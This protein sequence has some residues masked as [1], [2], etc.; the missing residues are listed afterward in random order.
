MEIKQKLEK[1]EN[2]PSLYEFFSF[3]GYPVLRSLER[4][5]EFSELPTGAQQLIHSAHL[6]SDIDI[7]QIFRIYHIELNQ[8][9]IRRTDIRRI[10]EPF[11][12]KYSHIYALFVFSTPKTPYSELAFVSPDFIPLRTREGKDG[13]RLR[14][15]TLSLNPKSPYRT[16]LEILNGIRP[17]GVLDPNEIWEKH[18]QAFSVQ[19]VTKQFYEGYKQVFNEL[20]TLLKSQQGDSTWAH[21]F[22]HQL[23]NRIMF[24]YFIQRKGWL[25]GENGEPAKDFI[26]QFW[27]AYKQSNQP[28]NTF[29][30][31]WLF[32]LF[33][34]AFNKH[35]QA[36]YEYPKWLPSWI[37]KSFSEAPYLNGGLYSENELDRQL[38]ATIPDEFFVHL[39]DRTKDNDGKDDENTPGFFERYNFT[40]V[41]SGRFDEEVAVD[42]EVI[43][44]VYESLVNIEERGE[45][46]KEID[47]RGMAGIFYTPR[48]EIDLMCRLSLVDYLTNHLGEGYRQLLNE[49]VFSYEESDKNDIDGKVGKA[50]LWNRLDRLLREV[51][52]CDPAC[53]SGSFLVGM[54][55]VLDDLQERANRYLGREE[56]PYERRKRIIRDQLYGVDVMEWAVHIAELRLWLQL[57]VE[58]ELPEKALLSSPLLPNLSFKLRSGDSLIQEVAGINLSHYREY[59]DIPSKLRDRLREL[60]EKKRGYYEGEQWLNEGELKAEERE[61]FLGILAHKKNELFKRRSELKLKISAPPQ[62]ALPGYGEPRYPKERESWQRELREVE[63]ELKEVDKVIQELKR[64]GKTPFLWNIAF[65]EIFS[66][67]KGGFDIVIGNPPYVRREKIA[68]PLMREEDFPPRVW[69]RLKKEYREKLQESVAMIWRDFFRNNR[70]LQGKNDLYVY[71]YFHALSLLNKKGSFC[72]ITSNSWLDVWFGKDLQEFLLRYGHPKMIIDN[73]ARRSFE[74]ADINTVIV[75]LAPPSKEEVDDE[76]KERRFVRFVTFKVPFEEIL[77]PVIFEEIWD[78][79]EYERRVDVDILERREYRAI[80]RDAYSLLVEGMEESKIGKGVYRGNK[81][82]G[83]YLRAPVI[84]FKIMEKGAGKL[85]KLGEIAKVETYLN[86]EADGFFLVRKVGGDEYICVIQNT[87]EEGQGR[88]F[89]IEARFVKPLIKSPNELRRIIVSASQTQWLLIVFPEK[90][91]LLTERAK[92]YIRWGERMGFSQRPGCRKRRPWWKLPRQAHRPG[93]IMWSRLHHDRHLVF[94]NPEEVAYTNFYA[95]WPT[96]MDEKVFTALLNATYLVLFRELVGRTPCGGGVLKTDGVDIHRIPVI[97]PSLVPPSQRARLICAFERLAQREVGSIFEELGFVICRERRCRNPEHPFEFVNSAELTLEQVRRASPDR[98]EL[99]SVVFDILGLTDEERL[100][101]YRAVADLVKS[102]LTKAR[103]V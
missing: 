32:Y 6:I 77:H 85:V 8:D 61:I 87:S 62:S 68:P 5:P 97:K 25:M 73:R 40:I 43:G 67:D 45:E 63:R 17:H 84:F 34:Y 54:L 66:K 3:L 15:R 95:I 52:V 69:E 89:E 39:F 74:Q 19:R 41:E 4:A 94:Y 12:R 58:T 36:R 103:S 75:L 92:E 48:V 88:T 96:G 29:Y 102:R 50:G 55:L 44:K 49:L 78:D 24:L 23:L 14:L 86:T 59:L 18:K 70:R 28:P 51:K 31:K 82:G 37:V 76:E 81:W 65:P 35:S 10:L 26:R 56:T 1:C 80:R 101:V 7:N 9:K 71:F 91:E 53:G 21:S 22:S 79:G 27:N 72:F 11:Y 13:I 83:I 64:E 99:D 33:F 98:F 46:E 20:F 38:Q 57:V 42:P 60:E 47:K 90:E 93:R 16:E 30:S 100:E 2:I